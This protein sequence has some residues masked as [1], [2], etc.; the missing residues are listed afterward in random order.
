MTNDRP[1]HEEARRTVPLPVTVPDRI[2]AARYHDQ[3][4]FDREVEHFWPHVWQMACRLEEIPG[5]GDFVEY[6]NVG[7]SVIVVRARDGEVKAFHNACRHRGVALATGRGNV[8]DGF[9]CPFHGWC[10]DLNGQNTFV[11]SPNHFRQEN[12][13]P[14]ELNLRPCRVDTWGG[15]AF[16]NHDDDAAPLRASLEPFASAMDAYNTEHMRTDWWESCLLPV[17]WRLVLG[18]FLEGYHAL[19]THPELY[20]PG[21]RDAGTYKPARPGV[22]YASR[23]AGDSDARTQVD[24]FLHFLRNLRSGMDGMI[25]EQEMAIAERLRDM[26]L[27]PATASRDFTRAIQAELAAWGSEHGVPIPDF[28]HINENN[29]PNG[30]W[31]AFPNVFLQP[32]FASAPLYR[33]RPLG[34]E[35]TLFEIWSLHPRA[36]HDE[37]PSP[38]EPT[39]MAPDD[40]RW[41]LI[42]A[43]DFANLPKQQ[44]GLHA[45]GFEYMRLAQDVEGMVSNLER[46]VDAYLAGADRDQ[47]LQATQH[48]SGRVGHVDMHPDEL[49]GLGGHD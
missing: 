24:N 48:T 30:T 42:P 4:Y 47:L 2:P 13:D 22:E 44:R 36:A 23:Y 6:S 16:I 33:I 12:L 26:D 43:Q 3:E 32:I 34:P 19:T 45:T 29:I 49:F 18:A 1:D 20:A 35:E 28:D 14:A 40:P 31:Y 5:P 41:P 8:S 27:S 38:P 46:L 21:T 39:P 10:Y 15:M 7:A 37:R 11:Y 9:I 17:N 25:S